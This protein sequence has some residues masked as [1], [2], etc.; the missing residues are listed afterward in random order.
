MNTKAICPNCGAEGTAGRFCEYCGTKIP[1]PKP[2]RKKKS[3]KTEL[4][5][6]R[7][8]NFTINQDDAIKAFLCH[9]SDVDNLPK[10]TF[11]RLT[12]G[13]FYQFHFLFLA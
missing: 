6:V 7:M 12:I 4:S 5:T 11:D 3:H 8:V 10:D 9:L 13:G 1:M 2:K